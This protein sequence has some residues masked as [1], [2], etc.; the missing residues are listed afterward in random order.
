MAEFDAICKALWP[1]SH[2]GMR[3]FVAYCAPA[4]ELAPAAQ[5]LLCCIGRSYFNTAHE[6]DANEAGPSASCVNAVSPSDAEKCWE[7]TARNIDVKGNEEYFLARDE[8]NVATGDSARRRIEADVMKCDA[9]HEELT[10]LCEETSG[11]DADPELRK[12]VEAF[13][14]EHGL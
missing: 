6:F 4:P 9:L 3:R 12:M 7:W 10:A 1:A 13:K 14:K 5:Q 8:A 11:L 2:L